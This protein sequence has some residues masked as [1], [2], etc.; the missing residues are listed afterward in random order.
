MDN[1]RIRKSL[2]VVVLDFGLSARYSSE[3]IENQERTKCC[4][5]CIPIVFK[6][7]CRLCEMLKRL[8]DIFTESQRVKIGD[9][10]LLVM[11]VCNPPKDFDHDGLYCMCSIKR[12][13]ALVRDHNN[14][15]TNAGRPQ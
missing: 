2:D 3:Q 9:L 1:V 12:Q 13:L 7:K 4:Q 15:G 5:S 8:W 11:P 14:L 6:D 10:K